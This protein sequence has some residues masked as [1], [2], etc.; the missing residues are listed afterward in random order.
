MFDQSQIRAL[1]RLLAA[2][3]VATAF[4]KWRTSLAVLNL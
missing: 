4:L 2:S 1:R 3:D